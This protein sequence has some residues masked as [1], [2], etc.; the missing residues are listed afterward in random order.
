MNDR[1]ASYSD[2]KF[3]QGSQHNS[4]CMTHLLWDPMVKE[5]GATLLLSTVCNYL[6]KNLDHLG[7][8][9][10]LSFLANLCIKLFFRIDVGEFVRE[11]G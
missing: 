9:L 6:M 7:I 1:L 4:F 11:Y 2:V 10:A 5:G 8:G 3:H